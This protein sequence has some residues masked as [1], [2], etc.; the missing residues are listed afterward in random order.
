MTESGKVIAAS[1]VCVVSVPN[2]R[3]LERGKLGPGDMLAVDTQRGLVLHNKDI[4]EELASLRPYQAWL[5]RSVNHVGSGVS[6][7]GT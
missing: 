4:K 5:E 6:L 7:C 2:E 1:E 3:I